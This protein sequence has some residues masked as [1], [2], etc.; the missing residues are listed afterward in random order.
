VIFTL[1]ALNAG[2]GDALLLHYG[3]S[4]NPLLAVIDGGP[5][6]VYARSLRPRLEQLRAARAPDGTLPLQLVAVSHIDDDHIRGIL[7]LTDGLR[8]ARDSGD[9]LDYQVLGIWHNSFDDIVG[10]DG[11]GAGVPAA[12]ETLATDGMVAGGASVTEPTRLVVASIGQG[13]KLRDNI[14]ALALDVNQPFG[15]AVVA[16]EAIDWGDGLSLTVLGPEKRRLDDLHKKW[17]A[18]VRK[19]QAAA[20]EVAAYLDGSVY[21]LSSIVILA[22]A[23][24]KRMLLTGDARGDDILAGLMNAELLKDEPFHVDIL[25]LPHHG[26]DRNVETDFFRKIVAD[27]YVVSGDGTD[28]N[29]EIAALKMISEARPL[30]DDDFTLHLTNRAGKNDIGTRLSEFEAGERAKGRTYG[31]EFREDSALSIGVDLLDPVGER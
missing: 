3:P 31:I 7:D 26:S 20:T 30:P 10:G 19:R 13:R 11:G 9:P 27:H 4:D 23:G 21:N 5:S 25:K 18:D 6:G 24:G 16:S 28:G 15:D 12:V 2:Q 17:D 29:P 1:E 8:E 14:A 22:E